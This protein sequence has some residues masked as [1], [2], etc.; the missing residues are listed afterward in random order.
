MEGPGGYQFIG[1]TVQMWNR[2]RQTADFTNGKPWLLRFFDQIR[3]YE[4]GAKELLKFREDFPLG[5]Y[6]LRIE[7]ETFRL[8]DYRKFLRE[9]EAS[10][11]TFK[12]NQQQSFEAE[13]KRWEASGQLN[14]S[15]ENEAS[16]APAEQTVLPPGHTAVIAQVPGNV[17]KINVQPGHRVTREQALVVLESM[18]MEIS[19]FPTATGEV[20]HVLCA[21]GKPVQAGDPLIVIKPIS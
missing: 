17:W 4:V 21:E 5:R 18:K 3:F 1:R 11:S 19:V 13:R 16:S 10:I 6:K 9:N 20:T 15:A 8:R 2:W 12:T 14:F 7:E